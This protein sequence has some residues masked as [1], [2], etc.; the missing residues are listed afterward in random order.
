MPKSKVDL[1]GIRLEDIAR[2]FLNSKK[3]STGVSYEKCLKR[4]EY[5]YSAGLKGFIEEIEEEMKRN[6]GRSLAKRVRPG[7]DTIRK[8]IAWHKEV[9]YSNNSTRQSIATLQNALKFYGITMHSD[10]IE[11]PPARPMRENDKHQWTLEQMKQLVDIAEYIRDKAFI[12]ICF[13][14]GLSIGDVVDLDY[15][16]MKRGLEEGKLPLLL[17][18][19]RKKTGV[20]IKTF[21]GR[22]AI[23]YLRE[24]LK[25]RG[26]LKG[27]DPLFTML[28]SRRRVTEGAIQRMLRNYAKKLDFILEED[29][30]NGY[31]P[32]RPHSLR[33]AFRSRLTG[34]MNDSLIEFFMGK[35]VEDKKTYINMP[36]DELAE[37]Y[38][39]YEHL[40]AI[41]KTSREELEEQGPSPLPEEAMTLIKNLETTVSTLSQKNTKL[42]KKFDQF[43]SHIRR[44]FKDR[45]SEDE[46]AEMD[47][48]LDEIDEIDLQELEEQERLTRLMKKGNQF[49]Q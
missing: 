8:F 40:L 14:S 2:R 43:Y 13:Q 44:W 28:G 30:E 19:Y 41:E 36:E 5:F 17:H 32:A 35:L 18:L 22:D 45:M 12:M 15:R 24:Y 31:N 47:R 25:T 1:S 4:F 34:K 48:V 20:E 6:Q 49:R 33:S 9:S 11:L 16:D 26:T 42:E 38:S 21:L 27:D 10:F 7:E 3:P 23:S 39:N 46:I 37:L 29:L